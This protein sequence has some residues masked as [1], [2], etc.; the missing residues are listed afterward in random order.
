[1]EQHISEQ[2]HSLPLPSS[3]VPPM[4]GTLPAND[5]KPVYK[6]RVQKNAQVEKQISGR[7]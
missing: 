5:N 4:W 3:E 1:L 7:W 6:R 2:K